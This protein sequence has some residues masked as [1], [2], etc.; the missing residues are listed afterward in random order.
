MFQYA[1]CAG[2]AVAAALGSVVTAHAA[3]AER[4]HFGTLDDGTQ[5]D[6]VTL[7][8]K[9]GVSATIISYGATLQAFNVPDRDGNIADIELGYDTIEGYEDNPNYWGATIG[10]YANRI[11][12]GKFTLDGKTYQLPLNDN[13][14]NSLHG[15]SKGWDRLPW[16]IVSVKQGK[17][18]SVT[19]ELVSP[20]GD[21]GYPGT[22][23][24]TATYTLDDN[25]QLT[26]DYD[27]TTDAPTVINM[28]NHAIVNLEGEGAE[29]GVLRHKLTIPASHFTPVNANLIP[30]GELRPVAGTVFDF[31]KG[32]V[33]GE[34]IRDGND[35]QIIY[36]RGYDHNFALDAG[37]TKEPKLA[38]R[39]EDPDS[40]R[41][42][43]VLT[44]EPGLQVYTGNFLD[45]T[46][47]GKSKHVYRMG[48]GIALEPQ[49]FPDTPNQPAF[50]SARLEPGKPYHHR[51]I[52]R[53][54]TTR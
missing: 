9:N 6:A 7:T 40:G 33:I 47:I 1:V 21:E 34:G 50:G 19:M 39:L 12:G 32:R 28:T 54:S 46:F 14:V 5:I 48:D 51:M 44:T 17:F 11:A 41:V 37:T 25:G 45:G 15:G 31:T 29:R 20:T 4:S 26:I 10:R 23:H 52:F 2:I 30:T 35:Q 27:A 24:A 13:G 36:G 22:V 42:L 38:A 49:R 18:A 43:E 53:V 3:T 16:K 8:G